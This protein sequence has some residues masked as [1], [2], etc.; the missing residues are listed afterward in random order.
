MPQKQASE[1]TCGHGAGRWKKPPTL[2]ATAA[3]PGQT[4][5]YPKA[6]GT[7]ILRLLGQY[8]AFGLF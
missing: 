8:K 3:L 2:P 5:Y 7:H 1:N 6:L 4:L